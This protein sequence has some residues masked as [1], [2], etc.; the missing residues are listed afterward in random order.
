M[1]FEYG[2]KTYGIEIKKVG[3]E[4]CLP[5][6]KSEL[7]RKRYHSLHFVLHGFGTLHSGEN[8]IS[9]GRG[10]VFLLYANE[11][12]TYYPNAVDPWSYIWVDFYGEELDELFEA[13]GFTREKPYV[14]MTDSAELIDLLKQLVEKYNGSD[15][16][17]MVCSAYTLLVFGRLIEYKNRYL[18]VSERGS[19]F[20][21][22]FRDIIDYINNNYRMNLTLEQIAEDMCVSER[23][24]IYMFRSNIEMTPINYINKFRISNACELLKRD[25][26]KVE[27]IAEMVGIE[28]EKYFTRMFTK[29][30]GVSPREYRK[31]CKDDD[32]FDW[33]KEKNIDFR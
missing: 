10:N 4:H 28:D 33:L 20:F 26:L 5:R 32:P 7:R 15:V 22:Q 19:V 25:D 17:S 21:K 14:R 1:E 6:K 23:Q 13:C 16:Q 9:L 30:K 31:V 29:W 3:Q 24:L 12:Y 8:K 2:G 11:E 27:E 18:K